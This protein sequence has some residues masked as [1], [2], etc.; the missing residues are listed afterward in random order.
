VAL[1]ANYVK[2][3][4]VDP[5]PLLYRPHNY[6]VQPPRKTTLLDECNFMCRMLFRDILPVMRYLYCF[7]SGLSVF[8]IE[9][10]FITK[11]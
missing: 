6:T 7:N 4:K 3:V 1:A 5:W 2:V 9:K 11:M 10:E 8:E